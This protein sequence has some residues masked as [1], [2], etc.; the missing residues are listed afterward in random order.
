M[1]SIVKSTRIE[2]IWLYHWSG[3]KTGH[4]YMIRRKSASSTRSIQ[5]DYIF[6]VYY[7]SP[8]SKIPLINN[9]HQ[10]QIRGYSLL[11]LTSNS[12]A[13]GTVKDP[14][15]FFT[16]IEDLRLFLRLLLELYQNNWSEVLWHCPPFK[17]ASKLKYRPNGKQESW[18]QR[19][20]GP[21]NN[22]FF[23]FYSYILDLTY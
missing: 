7:Y 19:E 20:I 14:D 6:F 2:K 4:F 11:S 23:V 5:M 13:S 15:Q 9:I 22:L 16:I 10:R 17:Y 8:T 3:S 21:S 18:M 1:D 12:K